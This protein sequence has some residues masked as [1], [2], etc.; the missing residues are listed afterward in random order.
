MGSF[1]LETMIDE[2]DLLNKNVTVTLG[3]YRE[4]IAGANSSGKTANCNTKTNLEASRKSK[5]VMMEDI[6]LKPKD[7]T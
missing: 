7:Q 4:T 1:E 5:S 3:D 2:I 6:P